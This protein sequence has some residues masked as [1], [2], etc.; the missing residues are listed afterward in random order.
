MEHDMINTQ[1][2]GPAATYDEWLCWE[3]WN[4]AG[5]R[6]RTSAAHAIDPDRDGNW[7]RC[8]IRIPAEGNGTVH[9]SD[10]LSDVTCRRCT[11]MSDAADPSR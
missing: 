10:D 11:A 2:K 3:T 4:D 9:E 6:V 8:G 1:P 7:T 5:Y